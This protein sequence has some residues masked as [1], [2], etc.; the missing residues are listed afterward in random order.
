MAEVQL[1]FNES[2]LEKTSTLYDLYSRLYEG[3]RLANAI[4]A[5]NF[6][7]NPPLTEDGEIDNGAIAKGLAEYSDILM[8]NSAYLYANA[9]LASIDSQGGGGS[10]TL[11]TGY[12][13]R[14]GDSM[15]GNLFAAYGFQAGE[16]GTIIIET[17]SLGEECGVSV[18]GFLDVQSSVRT[19][20]EGIYIDDAKVIYIDVTDDKLHLKYVEGI[21]LDS[22]VVFQKLCSANVCIDDDGIYNGDN[23][24]YHSGNSNLNT[25]SWTMKDAVVAGELSVTGKSK[26]EAAIEAFGGFSLGLSATPLLY[27]HNNDEDIWIKAGANIEFTGENGIILA[28]KKIL[29]KTDTNVISLMAPGM[30]LNFGGADGDER[31]S[32]IALQ[33]GIYNASGT[34]EMIS[35]QGDGNFPNSF[36]AG[37]G[38]GGNAVIKTYYSNSE[39]NGIISLERLRFGTKEGPFI[40]NIDGDLTYGSKYTYVDENENQ[41]NV[42]I[43]STLSYIPTASLYRDQSLPWSA[44]LKFDTEAEF[45]VFAKQV[46]ARSFAIYSEQ[47]K[48]RLI[49]NTLFLDDG[50]FIEGV[51]DGMRFNGNAYFTD[52]VSSPSFASGFAGY[53]WAIMSSELYGGYEATFDNL[54]VRKKMRIYE[55]E[56]QKLSV[57][58]GSLWVSDNCS[59]DIVEEVV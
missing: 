34:Y 53:G 40:Q 11:G 45:F 3:M 22:E 37:S 56:V 29:K 1:N 16:K 14:N 30:V 42:N 12:V 31:T 43:H 18:Y 58:N 52:S 23:E 5:P 46:E 51:T 47:Y 17:T 4:S 41:I 50:I 25:I 10:G 28:G 7:E 19:G 59:G 20:K 15:L 32:K 49:E 9:I 8:K 55:L 48:T 27:S 2:T 54:T 13:S 44:S 35:H 21:S 6:L 36:S 38:N 33:C 24:Y 57:T 26:F 39:D